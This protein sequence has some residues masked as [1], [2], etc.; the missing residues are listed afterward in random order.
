MSWGR[1]EH[2]EER[3][4]GV[5]VAV[6]TRSFE[7]KN[8]VQVYE[9]HDDYQGRMG[10][11]RLRR[12]DLDVCAIVVEMWPE[13]KFLLADGDALN[14]GHTCMT[15]LSACLP[16]AFPFCEASSMVMLGPLR[17]ILWMKCLNRVKLLARVGQRA[18][19]T[20]LQW[21]ATAAVVII[22]THVSRE[23]VS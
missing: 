7:P 11:A 9:P 4:A 18:R 16:A 10:A 2:P 19:A 6:S 21:R 17:A 13:P 23:H 12:G 22:T 14:C 15:L 20:E 8:I 5:S 1:N 3:A